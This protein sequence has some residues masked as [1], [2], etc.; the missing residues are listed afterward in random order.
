MIVHNSDKKTFS[1]T[2]DGYTAFIC[3]EIDGTVLDVLT[4]QVPKAISGRG[5]A[6]DLM[7]EC[8]AFVKEQKLS[9]KKD[10]SCSYAKAWLERN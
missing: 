10:Q 5:I 8:A 9:F 7:K 4:T 6:S 1:T 2:V 3:Y